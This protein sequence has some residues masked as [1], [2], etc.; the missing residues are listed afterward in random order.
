MDQ[1]GLRDIEY[2]C[3]QEEQPAC[4]AACPLHVD[5]R[6]FMGQVRSGDFSGARKTLDRTLPLPTV[7]GRVCDHPC[8]AHCVRAPIDA[9]LVMGSLERAVLS[10]TGPA[11]KPLSMP[12]KGKRAAVMGGDVSALTTAWDLGKKGY[13]VDV[14]F[15]GDAPGGHLREL[16]PD[17]LPPAALAAEIEI[18]GRMNVTFRPGQ[19]LDAALLDRL[20]AD[21][22]GVYV[23]AVSAPAL[24]LSKADADALTLAL[25]DREGVYC[26]GFA[27][28]GEP[29]SVISLAGDGRRAAVS[30]DRHLAGVSVT[31]SREREGACPTRLFTNTTGVIPLP[32]VVP[33]DAA[34][35]FSPDEAKA[36][37]ARCLDC[38]CLECVKACTYLARYKGYPRVYARQIYN[39]LSIVQGARSYN[40]MINSCTLCGQ[41]E[42]LCPSGFSMPDLILSARRDMVSRGKMPLWAHEFVLEDMAF[43]L[44]DAFRLMRAAPGETTCSQLFFPGC[45]LGGD[46]AASVPAVY[47]HLRAGLPGGVGLGLACCGAPA[48]WAGRQD[49]AEAAMAAFHADWEALG[50]PRVIAACSSCQATFARMAPDI[51]VVSLWRV[52]LDEAGLP[53]SSEA[54]PDGPVAIHDA[55]TGRHDAAGLAAV[56]EILAKLGIAVEELPASGKL[57]SCCGFGGLQANAHPELAAATIARRVAESPRDFVATCSMCRDRLA[58]AGKRTFHL[59][60]LLFP[61]KAADPAR[62]DPGFSYRHEARVRLKRAVLETVWNDPLP[63]ETPP[64]VRLVIPEAVRAVLETRHVLDSDLARVIAYAEAT[65]RKFT[66]ATTGRHLAGL[67]GARVTYWALYEMLDGVAHIHA[68]YSHRMNVT[69]VDRQEG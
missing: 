18:M 13:A 48:F 30:L 46:P 53:T 2:R 35:G 6:K 10:A 43:S 58:G 41:C 21:Y 65:G 37:A 62:P 29:L 57:A 45:Q 42:E 26:G 63:P 68:G 15:P 33:A 27:A 16:S 50:K 56:R 3:I 25:A 69:G 24:G 44:S 19:T 22:D 4:Q 14:Y 7:L 49:L 9:A 28:P 12:G 17:T 36:E 47:A 23:E 5:V 32:A 67:A 11:A 51:P 55:C 59:L 54:L 34:A 20:R 31:A 8:Q 1:Q 38:Q 61:S 39:N 40:Q 64:A 60:D 52:L 66:D